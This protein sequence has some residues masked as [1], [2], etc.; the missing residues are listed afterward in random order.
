MDLRIDRKSDV[1]ICRQLSE[2]IVFLIATGKLKEGDIL[3]SVRQ[4][5]MRH[6]I[7]ANTVSEAYKDLV[8]RKWITRQRGSRMKVRSLDHP[9]DGTREDLDDLINATIREAKK[10]GYTLQE[11]R[12][13]VRERLLIESPDHVLVVEDEEGMRRLLQH[14]LRELLKFNAESCSSQMLTA[15][16]GPA[17]GALVVCLPGQVWDVAPLMPRGRPLLVLETSDAENHVNLIQKL[18]NSS[19]I[20]IVS[21]SREFLHMAHSLLA[22][23]IGNRHSIEE[24]IL[25]EK[26]KTKNLSSYD[27]VF[28]DSVAKRH[29][30]AKR[31]ESYRLISAATV[32]EI[33]NRLT[34]G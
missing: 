13:R 10:R 29:I 16:L 24:H 25:D 14:E 15:N 4:V 34:L 11:L 9:F 32:Q 21:I 18:K 33:S 3:P 26:E 2:Q 12:A 23:V 22:P 20:G 5:A 31:V 8:E 17:I 30:R 19:V 27:L 1:T 7:H 28:C 6:K